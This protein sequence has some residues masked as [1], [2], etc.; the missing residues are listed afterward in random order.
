[1][2]WE[3]GFSRTGE[4]WFGIDRLPC[5][6]LSL[7]CHLD[8][9]ANIEGEETRNRPQNRASL[10]RYHRKQRHLAVEGTNRSISYV[11]AKQTVSCFS[12]HGADQE[13]KGAPK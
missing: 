7:S 5:F 12:G 10:R 2:N 9:P 6:I 13:K 11:I 3:S 8:G 4:P 1:M